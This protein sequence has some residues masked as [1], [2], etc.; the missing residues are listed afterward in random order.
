MPSR[1]STLILSV[2]T[3]G[4]LLTGCAEDTVEER[5]KT[6]T[7]T[8]YLSFTEHEKAEFVSTSIKEFKAIRAGQRPESL[9]DYV[10][11]QTIMARLYE[12]AA[13]KAQGNLLAPPFSVD[14]AAE[15]HSQAQRLKQE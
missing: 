9:C 11:D 6:L 15:C 5:L 3:F 2:L 12:N 1:V 7:G 10:L 4:F 8:H 14:S 13:E